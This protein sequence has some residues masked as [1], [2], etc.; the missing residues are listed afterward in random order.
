MTFF[1]V[2]LE[3][4]LIWNLPSSYRVTQQGVLLFQNITWMFL[5]LFILIKMYFDHTVPPYCDD[6][7]IKP[8]IP[9]V[10]D[11]VISFSL[12]MI[13]MTV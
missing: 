5:A 7:V 11:F 12:V 8:S 1:G 13:N 9:Y 6:G 3:F 10:T 2:I 4:G